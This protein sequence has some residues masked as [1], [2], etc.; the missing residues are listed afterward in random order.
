DYIKRK[1]GR[2][3][4]EYI[5]PAL[6]PFLEETY[7]LIVY[8]EQIMHIA[9]NLAGLTM[10][11]ALS[12]I[13]AISKKKLKLI[14]DR[15]ETFIAGAVERGMDEASSIAVFELIEYFAGYGFNKAH[16]TAYAYLTYRM[17]YLRAHYPVSFLAASMTCERG[18]RD[19]VSA[20]VKDA[21]LQGIGILP[22][23]VNSS[24]A[25]FRAEADS[26]RFGLSAVKGVGDK[27][28]EAIV[29]ARA[30]EGKP[31][32]DLFEFCER[33]DAR[34]V[35]RAAMDTLVRCGAF[36]GLGASRAQNLAI[37]DTAMQNAAG[38]QSDR[39]SGQKNMFDIF[40]EAEPTEHKLPDVPELP[41]LERLA[42]EKDLLGFY[43]T[44]HP[45]ERHRELL[46]MYC[47]ATTDKLADMKKGE[48][49]IV[50]GIID[51]VRL[52][53]TRKG[54]FE[55]QRWARFEFSDIEGSAGGV[56]FAQE[57][58]Q[59]GSQL[60]VGAIGFIQGKVDFQG[61]EPSLRAER[62]IPLRA[63]HQLLAGGLVIEV[64]AADADASTF[65]RLAETFTDFNGPMPVY[66][67]IATPDQGTYTIKAGR[68][69]YIAP[70]EGLLRAAGEI[71]GPSH[72]RFTRRNGN[73]NGNGK[74]RRVA[75]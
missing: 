20:F 10:G 44:G 25:E 4:I 33:V 46:E 60:K 14:A 29:A 7:G 68:S 48:E 35:N 51:E 31:F 26:I 24:F 64:D 32:E 55:G 39:A 66:V 42:A 19:Q 52:A 6:E 70:A 58:A 61:N 28:V 12:M 54:R 45:L 75:T 65:E 63:A 15:R 53:V 9:H 43:V 34:S 21:K 11:Q 23:H 22:P 27:A 49:V 74:S 2:A 71:V 16:S 5:H 67:R 73:G 47:T 18:N 57:Y 40:E 69:M 8:Q 41:E 72:V 37:L 36:D 59:N 62:I 1:H 56:M 38:A 13:K 17:A 30:K 3:K 50:G